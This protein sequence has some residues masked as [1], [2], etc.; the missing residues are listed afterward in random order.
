MQRVDTRD[1]AAAFWDERYRKA[2][3]VWTRNPNALLAG[4]AAGLHPA[5]RSTSGPA[6]DGTRSGWQNAG[7]A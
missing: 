2:D 6:R 7:G 4:F 1:S 3:R 5:A